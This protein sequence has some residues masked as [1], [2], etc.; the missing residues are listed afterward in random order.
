MPLCLWRLSH[1]RERERTHPF[2]LWLQVHPLVLLAHFLGG[3]LSGCVSVGKLLLF[4]IPLGYL[5][6]H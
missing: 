4:W 5:S 2:S 6:T 3:W 1:L